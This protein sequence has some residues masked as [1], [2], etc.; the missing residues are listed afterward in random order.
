[1]VLQATWMQWGAVCPSDAVD[2]IADSHTRLLRHVCCLLGAGVTSRVSPVGC[3]WRREA[4]R[5]LEGGRLVVGTRPFSSIWDVASSYL[6]GWSPHELLAMATAVG[7][8]SSQIRA[9]SGPL[10]EN[11]GL[12]SS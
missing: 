8:A 4:G 12:S 10:Q 2:A 6:P 9:T 1:M 7:A 11:R 3:Q 5:R